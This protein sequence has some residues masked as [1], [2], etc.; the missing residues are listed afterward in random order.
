[1]DLDGFA[2]GLASFAAVT[3]A[4]TSLVGATG[5]APARYAVSD[6]VIGGLATHKFS[7]LLARGSV[8]SPFR[9]PFTKFVGPG[10][11]RSTTSD[12]GATQRRRDPSVGRPAAAAAGVAGRP[13]TSSSRTP[14]STGCSTRSSCRG[15]GSWSSSPTDSG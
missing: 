12:P 4:V 13:R 10:G 7:R 6:L 14:S 15:T 1:V 9:A 2:G 11:R 3:T 8:T 5:R